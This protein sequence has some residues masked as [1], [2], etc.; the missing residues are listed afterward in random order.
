MLNVIRQFNRENRFPFAHCISGDLNER[1][2][3]SFF[4][5]SFGKPSNSDLLSDH[6]AYQNFNADEYSLITKSKCYQ[7]SF[8]Y[9]V[10]HLFLRRCTMRFQNVKA[11]KLSYG[12]NVKRDIGT[13]VFPMKTRTYTIS[14]FTTTII[15]VKATISCQELQFVPPPPD[16]A[17][18]QSIYRHRANPAAICLSEPEIETFGNCG[19]E[20]I[21]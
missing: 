2:C 8:I 13:A 11:F 6:L 14:C 16:S 1:R 3:S 9:Q 15:C 5:K 4:K 7:K 19:R 10:Q 20:N 18:V 21:S 12:K 17:I